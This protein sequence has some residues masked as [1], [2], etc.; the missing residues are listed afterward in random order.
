MRL[1]KINLTILA[2]VLLFNF[3]II[4]ISLAGTFETIKDGFAKTGTAAGY[5]PTATGAPK[6]EFSTAWIIYVNGLVGLM[7]ALFMI[8]V[9]YGGYLWLNARGRDEQVERA[10][11]LIIQAVIGLAIIIGARLI[12]ELTLTYVGG[13][14]FSGP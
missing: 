14:A 6:N 3:V 5:N 4:D 8:M 1:K 9:I 7:A 11:N 12:V 2:I 10:K 13:A